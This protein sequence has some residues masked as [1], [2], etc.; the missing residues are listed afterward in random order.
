MRVLWIF[1]GLLLSGVAS[2]AGNVWLVQVDIDKVS[3]NNLSLVS[4]TTTEPTP[5][6]RNFGYK[7]YLYQDGNGGVSLLPTSGVFYDK[8]SGKDT[9]C[10]EKSATDADAILYIEL[11]MREFYKGCHLR[12]LINSA[13]PYDNDRLD[14]PTVGALPQA[15]A[16]TGTITK[17]GQVALN[18]SL[19]EKHPVN[20]F[21]HIYHPDHGTGRTLG[22]SLSLNALTPVEGKD[23]TY[24]ATVVE[25]VTGLQRLAIKS[26]GKATLVRIHENVV[27][28]LNTP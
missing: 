20:P 5:V 18:V 6:T 4:A 14:F 8:R 25:E 15:K 23:N 16:A 13:I 21:R 3:E 27:L 1:A 22:R 19:D 7:F 2:A 26:S 9:E 28:G 17:N 10:A 12:T 24:S 11:N